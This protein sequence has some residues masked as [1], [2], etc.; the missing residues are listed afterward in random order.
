VGADW[1]LQS[2]GVP[3]SRHLLQATSAGDGD[4]GNGVS[5]VSRDKFRRRWLSPIQSQ[6]AAFVCAGAGRITLRRRMDLAAGQ[7]TLNVVM[8]NGMAT[9]TSCWESGH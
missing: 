6:H 9:S 2:D 7:I 3:D 1:C 5:W 4:G 8:R